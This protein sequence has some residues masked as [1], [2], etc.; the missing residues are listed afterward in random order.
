MRIEDCLDIPIRCPDCKRPGA[1]VEHA[2]SRLTDSPHAAT[3]L[4]APLWFAVS[5]QCR[6]GGKKLYRKGTAVE[7]AA[8]PV[9]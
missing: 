4:T 9:S 1:T 6:G 7:P 8:V 2:A 5:C 3:I